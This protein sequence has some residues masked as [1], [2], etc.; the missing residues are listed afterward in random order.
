MTAQMDSEGYRHEA[1]V[2]GSDEELLDVVVPFMQASLAARAPTAVSLQAREA[3]LVRQAIGEPRGVTFLPAASPHERPPLVIMRLRSLLGDPPTGRAGQARIIHHVPHPGLGAPWDGWCRCEAAVNELFRN[4]PGWELCLYD[5]RITP[6]YVLADVERTHPVMVTGRE[7]QLNDRYLEPG[8]FLL[9]LPPSPDPLEAGPPAVELAAPSAAV[10]RRAVEE[11][12]Q[13]NHLLPE[14]RQQLVTATSEA[15]T[16]AFLHGVHPVTLR[17][18]EADERMIVSVS[19]AGQGPADPY[20]GLIPQPSAQ[21]G[22]GGLGLWIV[23]QLAEVSYDR[24]PHGFTIRLVAGA[25][26]PL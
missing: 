23:N 3:D 24:G 25:A 22:E 4:V 16:N 26:V 8:R 21:E 11:V 7:H 20:A 14:E 5:R 12:A 15:V 6:S 17:V 10:S 2:Y 9:T 19:D 1:A 18:W 13:R